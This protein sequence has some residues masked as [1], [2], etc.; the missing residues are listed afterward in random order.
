MRKRLSKVRWKQ[1]GKNVENDGERT[2]CEET[3]KAFSSGKTESE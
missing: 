2:T 1:V 3:V